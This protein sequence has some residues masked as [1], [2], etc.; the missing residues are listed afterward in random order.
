MRNS[1]LDRMSA[2]LFA[3]LVVNSGAR[4]ASHQWLV[5][6]VMSVLN[7][8]KN[9]FR[10]V[11]EIGFAGKR[12]LLYGLRLAARTLLARRDLDAHAYAKLAWKR[13]MFAMGERTDWSELPVQTR[14]VTY[15]EV[16][17]SEVLA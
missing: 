16:E 9:C 4:I 17:E 7:C 11:K 1:A 2:V 12:A 6:V 10:D 3:E 8:R 14:E 15:F 13:V 5:K